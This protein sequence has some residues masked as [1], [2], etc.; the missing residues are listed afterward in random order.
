MAPAVSVIGRTPARVITSQRDTVSSGPEGGLT[1]LSAWRHRARRP[2][3]EIDGARLLIVSRPYWGDAGCPPVGGLRRRT[4]CGGR[5]AAACSKNAAGRHS[6]IPDGRS[7]CAGEGIA[8][9][10]AVSPQRR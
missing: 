2:G 3:R 4:A 8:G 7:G 5:L 10:P 9:L 1:V 6:P